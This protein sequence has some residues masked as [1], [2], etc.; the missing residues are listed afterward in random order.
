M[1]GLNDLANIP[2]A[3][4]FTPTLRYLFYSRS[5]LGPGLGVG[6]N[7]EVEYPCH[8]T[9]NFLSGHSVCV[10]VL[11]SQFKRVP[12]FLCGCY[13]SVYL[14]VC[15]C[16]SVLFTLADPLIECCLAVT[17]RRPSLALSHRCPSTPSLWCQGPSD[18]GG[19]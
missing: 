2:P 17:G 6:V 3:F 13:R 5:V 12:L 11:F 18:S 4:A 9:S 8:L 16:V 15:V 10:H 14:S 7:N 1:A 19:T